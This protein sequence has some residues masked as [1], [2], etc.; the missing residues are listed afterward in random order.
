M[1]GTEDSVLSKS[2]EWLATERVLL[3]LA[4]WLPCILPRPMAA[5][6]LE[7]MA[8]A[9]AIWSSLSVQTSLRCSIYVDISW[10]SV[11]K[12]GESRLPSYNN[13]RASFLASLVVLPDLPGLASIEA[14]Q[15]ST[16]S[17]D[18]QAAPGSGG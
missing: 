16:Q 7:R 11:T 5:M 17:L 1:N 6:R 3:R 14:V 9:S 2:S 8:L 12:V 4:D 18:C 13:P 15:I 10:E